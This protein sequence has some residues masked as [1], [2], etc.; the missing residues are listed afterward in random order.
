MLFLMTQKSERYDIGNV[1]LTIGILGYITQNT[2]LAYICLVSAL[3]CFA[4]QVVGNYLADVSRKT[5]TDDTEHNVYTPIQT[6]SLEEKT[7]T[8]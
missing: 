1:L 7:I 3:S 6:A 4:R 2:Y 5:K 8:N